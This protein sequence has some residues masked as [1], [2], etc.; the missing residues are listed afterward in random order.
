MM[1]TASKFQM[2]QHL[3]L[4]CVSLVGSALVAVLLFCTVPLWLPAFLAYCAASSQV[5]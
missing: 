4:F 5:K 3:V 2:L 1:N